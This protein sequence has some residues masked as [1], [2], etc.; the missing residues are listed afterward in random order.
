MERAVRCQLPNASALREHLPRV[1]YIDSFSIAAPRTDVTITQLYAALLAHLPRAFQ[2]LLVLRSLVVKPFGIAGVGYEDMKGSI[3]GAK[4]YA[5]GDKLGRWTL[6]AQQRDE[7]IT[8][9]NDKHLD[10]RVSVMREDTATVSRAVL[11]TAVM[12]HNGFGRAYLATILPF[13]RYGIT[14][15]LTDAAR[16]GRI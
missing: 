15:L 13:H 3:D 8:G 1:D 7:M 11:S 16:Q 14:R 2:H 12:T 4:A 10:F 9:N 5:V 6:Y